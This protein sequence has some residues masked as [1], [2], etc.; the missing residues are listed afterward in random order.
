[1]LVGVDDSDTARRALAHAVGLA[2]RH[3]AELLV[4]HVRAR[5]LPRLPS[6]ADVDA[7]I[8]DEEHYLAELR[9]GLDTIFD[10]LQVRCRLAVVEGDPLTL[11]TAYAAEQ[12][13]D[14]VVVGASMRLSHRI[15]GSL[16]ARLVRI[17]RWPVT[18]VP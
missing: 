11:L 12:E 4:L 3:D 7:W 17:A 8:A 13:V 2:R 5:P 6:G 10:E 18:V 14:A 15:V 16:A 1:V 9:R